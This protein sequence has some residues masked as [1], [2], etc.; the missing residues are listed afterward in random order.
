MVFFYYLEEIKPLKVTKNSVCE[1]YRNL[2]LKKRGVCQKSVTPSLF[3]KKRQ[4]PDFLKLGL[5]Y[6]L[7]F[8]YL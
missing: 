7:K 5:C 8:L 6:V 3:Q 1:Y 2:I 4:S